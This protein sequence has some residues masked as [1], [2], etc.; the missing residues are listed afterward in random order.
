MRTKNLDDRPNFWF[1]RFGLKVKKSNPLAQLKVSGCVSKNHANYSGSAF[2][3]LLK[4]K[5]R[6]CVGCK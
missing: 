6:N 5:K 1:I 4:R 3:V 2:P